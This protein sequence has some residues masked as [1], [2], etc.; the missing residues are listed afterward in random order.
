MS[1]GENGE[2]VWRCADKSWGYLGADDQ[3]KSVFTDEGFYKSGDLGCIDDEGY[4][5]ITGRIKDMILRG[6]RNISPQTIESALIKHRSVMDVAVAAMPD[7]ILGER[8]CA[9]V[10]LNPEA[11]L[12]FDDVVEFLKSQDLAVWQLPEH[13]VIVD[14]FPKGAGGKVKKAELTA[15]VTPSPLAS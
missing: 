7:P 5:R 10:I 1:R 14:D 3:T 11:S 4:L 8:A 13:L 9:F 2:V 12:T 6:G 15:L